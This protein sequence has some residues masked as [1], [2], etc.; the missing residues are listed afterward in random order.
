MVFIFLLFIYY[1]EIGFISFRK[2]E[3]AKLTSMHYIPASTTLMTSRYLYT[4]C[5]YYNNNNNYSTYSKKKV[6][7]GTILFIKMVT[8]T[9]TILQ[10]R[11]SKKKE[12]K[13]VGNDQQGR[14]SG[15]VIDCWLWLLRRN[16]FILKQLSM[17]KHPR[18]TTTTSIK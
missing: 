2:K 9:I 8:I 7:L 15:T 10:S 11:P 13:T 6:V 3:E 12:T 1:A 16:C 18:S 14:P 5:H 17:S 4:C